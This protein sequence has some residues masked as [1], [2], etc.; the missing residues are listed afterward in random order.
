MDTRDGA[1]EGDPLEECPVSAQESSILKSTTVMTMATLLSRASGLLRTWAM[2]FALGNTFLTSAYQVANNMP[3]VIYDLVA[4]GI[5]G[6][7]FLPVY[8]LQ[9][10]RLG[11]FGSDRFASN[12]LNISLVVLGLLAVVATVFAPAVIATQTFTLEGEALV[13]LVAVDFFRIFAI[14][15]VFYGLGGV[16]TGVLN[17]NRV[18]GLP[19]L[20]PAINN[21]VV[22]ISM[23]S[24]VPLAGIDPSLAITVLGI[25]TSLGVV[26]QFAIQI[27]ALVKSGFIY[28]PRINLR[29]P[30][31]KEALRIAAPTLIYIVGTLVSF[32]CRNA[33]SLETG[34]DGPS[35]LLFAWTWYQLPYG[36]VAVSLSTA[37]L[38]EMS[39]C[40]ARKDLDGLRVHIK[41]GLSTTLFLIIPLAAIMIALAAPIIQIFRAGEFTQDDVG[42]VSLVLAA[43]LTSLPFYAGQMFLYR[44]FAALRQFMAFA[45]VSCGLCIIQVGLYALLCSNGAFGLGLLGVPVADFV[46]YAL[47][48]VVMAFILKRRVGHFGMPEVVRTGLKMLG[49]SAVA[50]AAVMGLLLLF[51]LQQS[52]VASLGGLVLLGSVG[53]LLAFLVGRLLRVP[54]MDSAFAL[55]R[56]LADRLPALERLMSLLPWRRQ[57]KEG[58]A[59][60]KA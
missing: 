45:L 27:P 38:T 29:D 2:A 37:F 8:L 60:S 22:V 5:L 31:L 3:N 6:T 33:F 56:K 39:D 16:I 46:Y 40:V 49:A 34:E 52:I 51:P 19:A 24:Y 41:Q 15:L 13:S 36:V 42:Y 18:Y 44:V 11:R 7:A 23:F 21:I 9:K 28:V 43:W 17:A 4:G 55:L 10:E 54:E 30:A 58:H 26:A 35:T 14:Q 59:G 32:S 50:V 47:Q 53:L 12:I 48:F 25:G 1:L 20:A 57:A